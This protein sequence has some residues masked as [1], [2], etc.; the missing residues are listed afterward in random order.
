MKKGYKAEWELFHLL[1]KKG[2]AV[3]RVAG[4]GSSTKPTCDLIAG[5]RKER[6][7]IEV[8]VS[9]AEKKY[10]SKKQINELFKFAN[11]FGLKPL[12]FIKFLRKGWFV[13]SL[14]DL[15]ETKKAFI[16]SLEKGKKLK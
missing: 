1:W 13:F 16:A 10:V 2:Y 8:K 14:N 6:L 12:I 15:D 11:V 3:A 9:K 4:S 7:A 5:N